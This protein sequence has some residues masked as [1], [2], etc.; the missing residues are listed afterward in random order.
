MREYIFIRPDS[1]AIHDF[2]DQNGDILKLMSLHKATSAM[3]LTAYKEFKKK[4]EARALI[5]G[6]QLYLFHGRTHPEENLD[7]WGF[8]GPTLKGVLYVHVTYMQ[9]LTVGFN[10]KENFQKALTETGWRVWDDL[11]LEMSIVDDLVQTEDGYFG[12]WELQVPDDF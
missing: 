2:V 7:D 12:D 3:D 4:A 11:T 9:T 8:E 10:N 6:F 1:T 5:P